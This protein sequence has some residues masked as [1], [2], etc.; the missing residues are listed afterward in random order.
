MWPGEKSPGLFLSGQHGRPAA[1]ANR[2][3]VGNK[4]GIL[5]ILSDVV[6]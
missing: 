6:L 5:A 2:R 4:P 3:E 1:A